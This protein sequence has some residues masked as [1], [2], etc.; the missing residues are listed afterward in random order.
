MNIPLINRLRRRSQ[1][2]IALFQDVLIRIIYEIDPRAEIHGGTAI[3]RCYGG[4]RFSKDIDVYASSRERWSKTKQL[5]ESSASRYNA[6]IIKFKE[7]ENVVFIELLLDDI[8]SEI[9]INFNKYYNDP[10][11]K[12]YENLDGTFLDILTLSPEALIDEKISAYNDRRLITDI[13]DIYILI[14]FADKKMI[15]NKIRKFIS[16]IK[17]PKDLEKEE[18]RLADLIFE[19]PILSFADLVNSIKGRI[20]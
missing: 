4:K 20:T 5:L 1:K 14:N 17:E 16:S 12:Q 15:E 3:W 9:E 6:K 2:D 11:I 8:Y 10:V 13:Y 19:G 7:T 18:E